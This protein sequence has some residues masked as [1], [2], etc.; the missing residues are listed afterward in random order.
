MLPFVLSLVVSFKDTRRQDTKY[1]MYT[2]NTNCLPVMDQSNA[3][4]PFHVVILARLVKVEF[5]LICVIKLFKQ[6]RVK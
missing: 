3:I 6:F 5:L 2:E 1:I 4:S